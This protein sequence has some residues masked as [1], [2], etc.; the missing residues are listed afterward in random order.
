[1]S[2]ASIFS[3]VQC[4]WIMPGAYPRVEH[5]KVLHSF[6]LQPYLQTLN[7]AREPCQ[8]QTLQLITKIR[9]LRTKKFYNIGPRESS[10]KGMFSTVDLLELTCS[11]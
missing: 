1:M 2:L 8:G 9:Q 6:R 4:L 5:L 10:L 11:D 3:L 7:Y